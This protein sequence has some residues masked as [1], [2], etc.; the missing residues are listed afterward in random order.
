VSR[1]ERRALGKRSSANLWSAGGETDG[2]RG[3][4][5]STSLT[6]KIAAILSASNDNYLSPLRGSRALRVHSFPGL[7]ALSL[8]HSLSPLRGSNHTRQHSFP[9]LAVR[10][11]HG[12]PWATIFRRSAASIAQDSIC[13]QGSLFDVAH[14]PEQC[15]GTSLSLGHSLS[16]LRGYRAALS[17]EISLIV[18][19]P[20]LLQE[21]SQLLLVR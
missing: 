19:N 14:G 13:S 18:W 6:S 15:R 17:Q 11:A 12:S 9:G 10:Q 1:S 20:V 3:A 4:I 7:A 5:R 2:M 8:G 21:R 16:P